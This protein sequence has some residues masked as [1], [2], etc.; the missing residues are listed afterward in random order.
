MS[1]RESGR[2]KNRGTMGLPIWAALG[3]LWVA[4]GMR[5]GMSAHSL[6]AQG[7]SES[8]GGSAG[9]STTTVPHGGNGGTTTVPHGGSGGGLTGGTLTVAS[10]GSGGSIVGAGGGSG[11]RGGSITGGSGG[12]GGSVS[13][14]SGGRGGSI[15]GGSGGSGGRGG[16]ITGGSGGS[17][18]QAGSGGATVVRDASPDGDARVPTDVATPPPPKIDP[19]S[20]YATVNAGT[21]ILSGYVVSSAGG[22]GSTIGLT[23]TDTSF[24]ASGTVGASSTYRSWANASFAVN[25]AQSGG[26]GSTGSL[27]FVGSSITVSYVNKGGSSLELQLWDGSN[28][29]CSYLPPSTNPNVVNIPF[30]SLNTACWDMSGTA[31]VS[32]TPVVSVQ[33]AVP[34]SGTK[35]TPFDYCFLGMT[36][37]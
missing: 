35:A 36:I 21:V 22:S 32:G 30:S 9:T 17:G 5:T 13:G 27:P 3:L 33:L 14:G 16:T 10:G 12:S 2:S 4:C 28:F 6:D 11:G 24:C 26:S 8:H 18:G 15:T 31:F 29:W 20:G 19:N 34:G 25:Q 37:Q 23:C 1:P 7:G